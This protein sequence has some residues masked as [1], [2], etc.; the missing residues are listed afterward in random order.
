MSCA[1]S[2]KNRSKRYEPEFVAPVVGIGHFGRGTKKK[3]KRGVGG[4]PKD[5]MKQERSK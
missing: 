3:K 2:K 4:F 1:V 5:P